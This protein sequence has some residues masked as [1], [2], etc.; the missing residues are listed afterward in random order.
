MLAAVSWPWPSV[1]AVPKPACA[2]V[3]RAGERLP[4]AAPPGRARLRVRLPA[5]H[6]R[7]W[8]SASVHTVTGS[9]PFF[10]FSFFEEIEFSLCESLFDLLKID[11]LS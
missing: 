11:F 2:A 6:R 4:S 9:S 7:A 5:M 1:L 10:D 3:R 8:L